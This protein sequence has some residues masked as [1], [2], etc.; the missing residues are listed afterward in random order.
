MP[1]ADERRRLEPREFKRISTAGSSYGLPADLL[2]TAV[3]R[4]GFLGLVIALMGPSAYLIEHFT[5]PERLAAGGPV[6]FQQIV[7]AL[8]FAAGVSVFVAAWF[9]I[10]RLAPL[11]FAN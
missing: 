3:K 6:P 2:Q 11:A 4:L 10:L 1:E 7:A 9:H 8:L 5:Q